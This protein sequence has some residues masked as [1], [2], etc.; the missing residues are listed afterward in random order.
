MVDQYCLVISFSRGAIEYLAI[1]AS[2]LKVYGEGE[3]EVKK[4]GVEGKRQV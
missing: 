2:V 3:W 4:Y 1:D